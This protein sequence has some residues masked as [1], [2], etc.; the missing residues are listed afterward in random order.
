MA[1][2]SRLVTTWSSRSGSARTSAAA[3]RAPQAELN[4]V[5]VGKSPIGLDRL[6]NQWPN[7]DA[8]EIEDGASGT[9]LLDIENVVDGCT[10]R[11]L[12]VCAIV[13][14]RAIG[15]GRFP[16]ALPIRR[17]SEPEIEVNGVRSSWLTVETNSSFNRSKRLRSVA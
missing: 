15:R 6:L 4:A 8:P 2:D 16:A 9:H 1:F 11:W 7:L 5:A 14:K 17:P 3:T 10:R 12:L 13:S